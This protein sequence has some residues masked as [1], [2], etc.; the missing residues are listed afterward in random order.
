MNAKP[1][2]RRGRPQPQGTTKE[3]KAP[4]T[5]MLLPATKAR[6]DRVAEQT[7]V[8]RSAFADQALQAQFKKE[9]AVEQH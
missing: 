4:V 1:K 8:S 3:P 2:R 6:L 7:G 5:I 9:K